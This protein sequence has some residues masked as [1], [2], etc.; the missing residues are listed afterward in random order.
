MEVIGQNNDGFH[1]EWPALAGRQER[2]AQMVDMF[3]EESPAAFQDGDREKEGASRNNG[4][5]V[6]GH[7]F[8]YPD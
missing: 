2:G 8:V 6:S 3:G 4:A 1:R 5:A 7:R